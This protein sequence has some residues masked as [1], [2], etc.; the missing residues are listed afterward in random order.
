MLNTRVLNST[1]I[2]EPEIKYIELYTESESE[3]HFKANMIIPI[4]SGQ[5]VGDGSL[6]N[7]KVLN[8]DVLNGTIEME[9]GAWKS[10]LE[11]KHFRLNMGI[12]VSMEIEQLTDSYINIKNPIYAQL[13]AEQET[14]FYINLMVIKGYMT[15]DPWPKARVEKESKFKKAGIKRESDL[16]KAGVSRTN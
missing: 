13:S 3:S 6:L 8:K 1:L 16:K 10:E 4:A 11:Y 5:I 2:N 14:I 12:P 7:T 9:K 15:I